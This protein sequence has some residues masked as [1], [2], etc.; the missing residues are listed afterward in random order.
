MQLQTCKAAQAEMLRIFTSYRLPVV[1]T[2]HF[3]Q[4]PLILLSVICSRAL[5]F[6]VLMK[7]PLPFGKMIKSPP[8]FS[9][10]IH[11]SPVGQLCAEN[12]LVLV[13]NETR[14]RQ[15]K[16]GQNP[17][18]SSCTVPPLHCSAAPEADRRTALELL[19]LL[20]VKPCSSMGLLWERPALLEP[21][22]HLLKG[23][24]TD[25]KGREWVFARKSKGRAW[26]FLGLREGPGT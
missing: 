12:I 2:M 26:G 4:S 11:P 8:K 5:G 19:L 22:T 3:S 15:G 1:F 25:N 23:K 9:R 7:I 16:M 17:L 13:V 21:G 20:W 6:A 14:Q 10:H 24:L 18:L